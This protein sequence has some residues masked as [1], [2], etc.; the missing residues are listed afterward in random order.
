M[1]KHQ[2]DTVSFEYNWRERKEARYNHW[3][4]GRPK[5][6]IQLA[7]RCHWEVFTKLLDPMAAT[8]GKML[9]V[10]AGRGTLSSYF[11]D[12]G[13]D[14]TLLD[15]S[16]SVIGI[17]RDIFAT[18]GHK[19]SFIE[20]DA[21]D[22]P[23]AENTFDVTASI[24]LLE[25]F[26]DVRKPIIE[27]WRVLKPGGWFLG[28]IVPEKPNNIQKY[29][30]WINTILKMLSP[31]MDKDN[32]APQKQPVYR[33]DYGSEYYI[34]SIEG[35]D[36]NRLTVLGMYPLPMISHSPEFPFSLLPVPLEFV[37]TRLFEGVLTVRK[38]ITGRHGWICSEK[39]GQ[40]FLLAFRKPQL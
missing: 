10:G 36:I 13:W 22:L 32:K 40:A 21:N 7:F 37:L 33:N 6:Q 39:I 20:G 14:V 26:E 3:I 34:K 15:C 18:Q 23:F 4:K 27:Q 8:K 11:A 29:F 17:A 19:A 31:Q 1:K 30:C 38:L 24:G 35:I 9:E 12:A 16:P 5:N 28:Y 25:H 2:G